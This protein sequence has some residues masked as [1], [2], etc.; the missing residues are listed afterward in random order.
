M[1]ATLKSIRSALKSFT[2]RLTTSR[3]HKLYYR[4]GGRTWLSTYWLGTKVLKCPLDLWIYQE[5][6]HEVG[7]DLIIEIGTCEGGSAHFMASLCEILRRG[8]VV[9]IDI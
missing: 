5:I 2:E 1:K 9:T 8:R 6:I 4:S 7:P 3:F